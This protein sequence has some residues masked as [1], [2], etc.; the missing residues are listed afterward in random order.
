MRPTVTLTLALGGLTLLPSLSG[1]SVKRLA[2]NS[3]GD[4]LAQGGSSYARDDDPELVGAAVPFGLKTIESLLDES[5]RHRGLLLAAARGFTQYAF[6]W[7]QQEADF[8]EAD[9]LARATQLRD[10]ARR[11]YLRAREYGLRGLEV[12]LPGLREELRAG[13]E[14]ALGRAARKHVPLLH[15]TG[16]AWF[17]AIALAKDDSELS[18]DQYQ[19]EALMR[20]ALAL[21]EGYERG[22]IHDFFISWESRAASAGGSYERARGHLERALALAGGARAWPLV[23]Y[24][25]SSCV[26]RQDRE[27]FERVID[28]ALAVEPGKVADFRLANVLAQRRAAWLRGR[29]EELFIE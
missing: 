23:A 11:L 16:L 25:E 21:D 12:E 17:G 26:A 6:A 15:A 9:D 1:C 28:R 18:A 4:A 7:V 29:A 13:P 22:S 5:P 24:A 8:V 3:L 2:I 19:A 20:R 27:E 10:R 14:A